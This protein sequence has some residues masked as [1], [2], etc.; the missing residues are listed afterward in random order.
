MSPPARNLIRN[1]YLE[2]RSFSCEQLCALQRTLTNYWPLLWLFVNESHP[3]YFGR[4][5][6]TRNHLYSFLYSSGPTTVLCTFEVMNEIISNKIHR[7]K[8][9]TIKNMKKNMGNTELIL[10]IRYLKRRSICIK[11]WK[12]IVGLLHKN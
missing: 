10:E 6:R 7:V 11:A 1:S 9:E 8:N 12:R 4:L 2:M 3:P 5:L